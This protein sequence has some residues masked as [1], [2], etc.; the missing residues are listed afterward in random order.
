MPQLIIIIPR[1]LQV[2]VVGA[3]P[4]ALGGAVLLLAAGASFGLYSIF[5][6]D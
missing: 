2:V 3:P 1:I 5:K 6:K 4:L